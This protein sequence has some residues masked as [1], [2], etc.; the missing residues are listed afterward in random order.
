VVL[1]AHKKLVFSYACLGVEHFEFQQLRLR[2]C[3]RRACAFDVVPTYPGGLVV[4]RLLGSGYFIVFH[5][6]VGQTC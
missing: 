2:F 3:L 4:R 5:G 1:N 6:S